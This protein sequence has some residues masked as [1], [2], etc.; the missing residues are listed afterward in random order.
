MQ[1][2]R[3]ANANYLPGKVVIVP[4][5]HRWEIM[6][7]QNFTCCPC[8]RGINSILQAKNMVDSGIIEKIGEELSVK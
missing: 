1:Y 3:E 6:I 5:R 7:D 2:L 4:Y 8:L